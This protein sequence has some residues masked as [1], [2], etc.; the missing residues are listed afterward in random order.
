[1]LP[2]IIQIQR[3]IISNG[4]RGYDI[5]RA[6]ILG[7]GQGWQHWVML[8]RQ[9]KRI[10]GWRL[11]GRW[12]RMYVVWWGVREGSS[13]VL[14]IHSWNMARWPLRCQGGWYLVNCICRG[15]AVAGGRGSMVCRAGL[16]WIMGGVNFVWWVLNTS[17][18]GFCGTFRTPRSRN[19]MRRRKVPRARYVWGI[20]HVKRGKTRWLIKWF[21]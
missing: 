20:G 3:T 8:G 12:R 5:W 2:W 4:G 18:G 17:T 13:I 10:N 14:C 16:S 6:T 7:S 1:M 9:W 15:W 11:A 19:V 21:L